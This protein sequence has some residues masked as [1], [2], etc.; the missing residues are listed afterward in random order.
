MLIMS[1]S[2]PSRP[3]PSRPPL[4]RTTRLVIATLVLC[5]AAAVVTMILDRHEIAMWQA[6]ESGEFDYDEIEAFEDRQLRVWL[7]VM[8]IYLFAAVAFLVWIHRVNRAVRQ[9]TQADLSYTPGWS[10][11]WFLVPI[12][13][14]FMPYKVV[15]ELWIAT[16]PDR[17]AGLFSTAGAVS[18]VV[19]WWWLLW[20][21]SG[22]L[23]SAAGSL[24]GRAETAAQIA[25]A[26]NT[27]LVSDVMTV[28]A[29]VLG[30][31]L[32]SSLRNRVEACWRGLPENALPEARVERMR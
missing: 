4:V 5:A 7:S 28:G 22:L 14:L 18:P 21:G 11:G 24:Y 31:A 30:I 8:A 23:G 16:E 29:A 20:I 12:A 15:K 19:L 6:V 2:S 26:N 3:S 27:A 13:N 10:V 1:V 25:A 17:P 32:V 9:Y